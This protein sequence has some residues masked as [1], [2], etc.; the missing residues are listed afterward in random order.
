MTWSI[1]FDFTLG[2]LGWLNDAA[3][4]RAFG[5]YNS[6]L[7]W[8]SV[9]GQVG[10]FDERLYLIRDMDDVTGTITDV[11][12][13]YT[14]V[15]TVG[16]SPVGNVIVN[17][18]VRASSSFTSPE[19]SS[20]AANGLTDAIG[21]STTIRTSFVGG[22]TP[23]VEGQ[24][25]IRITKITV[26]G[27]GTNP[28]SE[29]DVEFDL[30]TAVAG[31]AGSA[32]GVSQDGSF[33]FVALEDTSSNQKILKITRPT[34]TVVT[35]AIVYDPGA[36]TSG[37]IA[38]TGHPD[39]MIFFGNFGTD[40]GVI[41]HV[42][43]TET[44]ND[45]SPASVGSKLIQPLRADPGDINHII[46]IN[47]DDQDAIETEDGSSWSTLNATLGIT[48]DAMDVGFF[49]PYIDD[50]GV[51][52]GNDGADE[53]LSY[54]PNEFVSLREDTSAALQAVGDIV[55]IDRINELF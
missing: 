32:L 29:F 36:G 5:V 7:G 44:N 22:D 2:D 30:A 13:F 8:D 35:T 16:G 43:S 50:V 25:D 15:G 24:L 27:T 49:G 23:I 20:I 46:A 37:N 34:S 21:A 40:V 28:F 14:T 19:T 47:R 42:I 54:S 9:W 26:A 52:G 55:S 53:N 6:G 48:V 38:Q 41:D 18:V 51:I 10:N 11:E 12:V 33:V 4:S 39:R 3:H 1:T 17:D 31:T 45:I